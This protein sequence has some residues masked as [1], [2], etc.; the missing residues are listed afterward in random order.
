[1][2]ACPKGYEPDPDI[3]AEAQAAAPG[4]IRVTHDVAEAARAPTCSTPTSDQHG[5]GRRGRETAQGVRQVPDQ[6]GAA[7]V[8]APDALVMHC[9]PAHRGEE[10]TA[11]VIDG[12]RAVVL[13]QAENRCTS[14]RP[15]SPGSR[16]TGSTVGKRGQVQFPFRK[17][18]LSPFRFRQ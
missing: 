8:A 14:R 2:L 3:M 16:C 5:P 9:L 4:R 12:P 7:R 1:V 13:E 10:I 11:E 6:L 18:H 17:L 15:S